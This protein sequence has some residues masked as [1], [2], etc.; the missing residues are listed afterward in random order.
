MASYLF[1]ILV[2]LG[3]IPFALGF[4]YYVLFSSQEQEPAA[5]STSNSPELTKPIKSQLPTP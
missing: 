5:K 4:L 2:F 3:V 1:S